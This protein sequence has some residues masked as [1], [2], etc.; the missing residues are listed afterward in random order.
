MDTHQKKN[1]GPHLQIKS[2]KR[3]KSYAGSQEEVDESRRKK[4]KKIRQ[5]TYLKN[6][7]ARD[8][9]EIWKHINGCNR[10]SLI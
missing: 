10:T 1:E 5:E 6:N 7:L 3:E 4:K 8:S 2:R 9:A